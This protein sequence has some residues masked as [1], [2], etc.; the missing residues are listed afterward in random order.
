[1]FDLLVR[2][3]SNPKTHTLKIVCF[4]NLPTVL[5]PAALRNLEVGCRARGS[6]FIDLANL[7]REYGREEAEIRF[8]DKVLSL[9][10]RKQSTSA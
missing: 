1:M 7:R 4:R 10:F 2:A 6:E 9:A 3:R 8:R 5:H